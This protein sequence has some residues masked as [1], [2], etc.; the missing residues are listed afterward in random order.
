MTHIRVVGTYPNDHHEHYGQWN[1]SM[2]FECGSRRYDSSDK[3]YLCKGTSRFTGHGGCNSPHGNTEVYSDYVC[4]ECGARMGVPTNYNH[5][6]QRY[7]SLV[8]TGSEFVEES[9]F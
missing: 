2:T 9:E 8:W 1:P 5:V 7:N 4:E 6:V 3:I